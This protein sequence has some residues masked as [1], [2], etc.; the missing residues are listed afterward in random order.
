MGCLEHHQKTHSQNRVKIEKNIQKHIYI[1]SAF[2]F[3][4]GIKT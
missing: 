4:M 1:G 3:W 2:L